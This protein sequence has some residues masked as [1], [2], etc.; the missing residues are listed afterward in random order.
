[1]KKTPGP[2]NIPWKTISAEDW[3]KGCA[4]VGRL[5]GVSR[6][7]ACN[8][9][10][11]LARGPSLNARR[12]PVPEGLQPTDSL[13]AVARAYKVSAPT[14]RKWL[15]SVGRPSAAPGRPPRV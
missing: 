5:M 13:A 8:A 3:A 11:K 1:M 9:Y 14:A 10:K 12:R 15:V 7:A 2:K 6:M 4:H